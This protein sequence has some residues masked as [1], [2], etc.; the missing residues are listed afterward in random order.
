MPKSHLLIDIFIIHITIFSSLSTGQVFGMICGKL[1]IKNG[2]DS[3]FHLN[4]SR[5]KKLHINILFEFHEFYLLSHLNVV[6]TI[7]TLIFKLRLKDR[8]EN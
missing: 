8:T 5:E 7:L 3:L 6:L 2:E 1:Y 4:N